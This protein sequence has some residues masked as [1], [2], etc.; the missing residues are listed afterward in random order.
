MKRRLFRTVKCSC[1]VNSIFALLAGGW[2]GVEVK[3]RGLFLR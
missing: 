1:S 3:T 2:I